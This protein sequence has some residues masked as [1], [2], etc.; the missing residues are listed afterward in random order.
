MIYNSRLELKPSVALPLR[1]RT[2]GLMQL[3]RSI[4]T[5]RNVLLEHMLTLCLLK[6]RESR[7]RMHRCVYFGGIYFEIY[8]A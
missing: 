7:I 1:Q 3:I 6:T 5:V 2:L 4:R 8:F